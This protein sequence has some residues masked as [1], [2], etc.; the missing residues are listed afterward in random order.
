[1]PPPGK[2][3]MIDLRKARVGTKVRLL[4]GEEYS[5]ARK[6]YRPRNETRFWTGEE[7]TI[8]VRYPREEKYDMM[9]ELAPHPDWPEDGPRQYL[10]TKEE[11]EQT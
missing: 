9:V 6:T 8:V 2:D 11:V 4:R 3:A 5:Y 1:M 10:F 7:G